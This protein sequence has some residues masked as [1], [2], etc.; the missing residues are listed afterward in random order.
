MLVQHWIDSMILHY[1]VYACAFLF[2]HACPKTSPIHRDSEGLFVWSGDFLHCPES[3]C[4]FFTP[5]RG[6]L[7]SHIELR[8]REL[9]KY[10]C[11]HCSY[12]TN[13]RPNL[14]RHQATTHN[15][16]AAG[17]EAKLFQCSL[18]SYVATTKFAV[19]SHLRYT[20]SSM[21]YLCSIC[22]AHIP[23]CTLF[24]SSYITFN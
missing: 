12:I 22:A 20:C 7:M 8:H 1:I 10:E 11:G 15:I 3:G 16:M 14:K 5:Y 2:P 21:Q 23:T 6:S 24:L 17:A 13:S 4:G 9:S 18:C 19:I